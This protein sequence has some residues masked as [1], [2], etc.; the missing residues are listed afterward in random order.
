VFTIA[1]LSLLSCL[2]LNELTRKIQFEERLT[3]VMRQA[4]SH[5][6][7]FLVACF[8]ESFR[9]P[10]ISSGL[11]VTLQGVMYEFPDP[12]CWAKPADQTMDRDLN[13][14]E[15]NRE[16]WSAFAVQM[17]QRPPAPFQ[18]ADSPYR[19]KGGQGGLVVH[20]GVDYLT[21]FWMGREREVI[22]REQ[23]VRLQA[24]RRPVVVRGT[25]NVA[26]ANRTNATPAVSN[27][28]PPAKPTEP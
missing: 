6:N 12:P 25:D 1:S 2:E 17:A 10:T 22:S 28:L 20:P 9:K 16:K 4:E 26:G 21:A 18:R 27:P 3:E 14:I 11:I 19:L 5:L 8:I 13:V 7:P 15:A 24:E 23:Y